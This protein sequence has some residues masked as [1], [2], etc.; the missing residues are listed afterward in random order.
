MLLAAVL[1]GLP[2]YGV[3]SNSISHPTVAAREAHSRR[4]TPQVLTIAHVWQSVCAARVGWPRGPGRTATQLVIRRG[5][6]C[7]RRAPSGLRASCGSLGSCSTRS[8]RA[9]PW[10]RNRE[11]S[12]ALIALGVDVIAVE[13]DPAMLTELRRSLPTVRALGVAPRRYRSP[14][15]PWML[16]S[17][18]MPCTGSTWTSRD[19]R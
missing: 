10:C 13:P 18:V 5:S 3:A 9:R 15:H 1:G 16:W 8:A 14:T 17:P 4:I 6:A 11:L 19:P 2:T 12:A 7:I